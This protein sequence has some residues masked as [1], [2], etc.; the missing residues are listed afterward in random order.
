M[1]ASLQLP[2]KR[3]F[4]WRLFLILWVACVIATVAVVPYQLTMQ[5]AT[6]A[7]VEAALPF[8]LW[9]LIIIQLGENAVL[10]AAITALGLLLASRVG[11]GLPFLENWL[12]GQP[13]WDA[14]P[15]VALLAIPLG[16]IGAVIVIGLDVAVFAPQ[17]QRLFAQANIAA[18]S[19]S[20]AW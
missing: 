12:A 1:T 2:V 4:N 11:L 17:M 7:Q 3:P 10:L 6:L 20:P 19:V 9:V 8:P 18:E 5:S 14:L 15:R 13:V 16:V